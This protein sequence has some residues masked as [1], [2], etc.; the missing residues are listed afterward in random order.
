MVILAL[1]LLAALAA[2]G[3]ITQVVLSWYLVGQMDKEL[4]ATADHIIHDPRGGF[5]KD[6]A[7]RR[8][9]TPSPYLVQ[10]SVQGIVGPIV[11]TGLS[12]Q[13]T[14]ENGS[15][16]LPMVSSDQAALINGRC[17]TVHAS[18]GSTWRA[19]SFPTIARMSSWGISD[20]P[21]S[22]TVAEQLN[23]VDDAVDSLRLFTTLIG[24]A[25]AIVCT[26]LG[27][28]AIRRS[29]R[30]LIEVEETAAA[31][32]SGDL[33]RRIPTRPPTTEVGRLT[34]SLNGMLT[35]IES[36]F[37]LR[38]ASEA[39]TRRFAA[40]ASH[41][42]RTPLVS[43]RGFAELYRQGAVT[44]EDVPRVMRRIEDEAKRMG[45]LVE[46]LLLLARLD[47]QRPSRRDPVD[48][49]KLARDAAHDAL[50]L[51]PNRTVSVLALGEGA[52]ASHVGFDGVTAPVIV[53]G[54]EDRLRQVV[55]NL[56]GNAVHHT[57]SSTLI[58]IAVGVE[59]GQAIL[60][61]RDHGPG[62]TPDQAERVFERF[63]RLDSSRHR[64]D[65]GG[66]GLGLSI[67]AAVIAS[68][69]GHV[70]VCPTPGG[71]ATF[72]VVLPVGAQQ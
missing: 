8:Q 20:S 32:A 35:Q 27:S 10:L 48:L 34:T 14:Q 21:A 9:P 52:I 47:A 54:D 50:G 3:Y 55:W 5:L 18:D 65:G 19:T 22:I 53:T 39:R 1:A 56:V 28:V 49:T 68:H 26:L 69:G 24:A 23:R 7:S 58:E 37:R 45:D 43:I 29:F 67:V 31:I 41:E 60:E 13:A 57:P 40:D 38:E 33:S 4:R 64:G 2:T 61:V 63:F 16:A 51:D 11:W 36:A 6:L 62:L 71:G 59:N 44:A 46:D 30:P 72:R 12:D 66:S 25:L 42:L 70:A 15:L 17:Y